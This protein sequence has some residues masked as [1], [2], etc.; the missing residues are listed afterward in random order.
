MLYQ[1]VYL[2]T[3]DIKIIGF[4]YLEYLFS[5]DLQADHIAGLNSFQ[6]KPKFKSGQQRVF[7][8]LTQE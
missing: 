3:R 8:E 2:D 6:S 7:M 4:S 5:I 1:E